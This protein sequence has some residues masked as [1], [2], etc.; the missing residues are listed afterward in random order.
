MDSNDV[1]TAEHRQRLNT[2]AF[3]EE[4]KGVFEDMLKALFK[5]LFGTEF[6][7]RVETLLET[8]H[9]LHGSVYSLS[10]AYR[11]TPWVKR[12]PF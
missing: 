1:N 3:P 9:I 12:V 10:L 2:V 11:Q 6:N 7:T 5:T 8:M 4:Q